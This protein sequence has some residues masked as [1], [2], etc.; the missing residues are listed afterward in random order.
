MPAP[1]NAM[2]RHECG[3]ISLP[4][5]KFCDSTEPYAI[6]ASFLRAAFLE[7]FQVRTVDS[8][9]GPMQDTR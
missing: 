3:V 2:A 5:N 1:A 4:S 9:S 8:L 6:S 7:T